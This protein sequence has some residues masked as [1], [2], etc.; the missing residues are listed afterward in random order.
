MRLLERLSGVGTAVMVWR[1]VRDGLEHPSG[2]W[3]ASTF[4]A[5]ASVVVERWGPRWARRR[6]GTGSPVGAWLLLTLWL[7]LPILLLRRLW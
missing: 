3:F 7:G 4:V 1:R 5:A 2:V 6:L